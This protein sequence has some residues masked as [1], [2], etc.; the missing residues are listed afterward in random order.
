M[1]ASPNRLRAMRDFK[2]LH[3]KGS[4]ARSRLLLLR[5]AKQPQPADTRFAISVS[6]KASKLAVTRNR[7]R[8]QVREILR[9]LLPQIKPGYD[10]VFS[11]SAGFLSLSFQEKS[12]EIE[13]VL[14]RAKLL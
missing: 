8:R 2:L 5:F 12:A 14:K 9:K 3:R 6:K 13:K 7:S 11:L 4:S 10:A 1:L